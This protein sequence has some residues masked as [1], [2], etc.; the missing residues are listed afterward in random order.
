[1]LTYSRQINDVDVAVF[2]QPYFDSR[3]DQ[4]RRGEL[5]THPLQPIEAAEFFTKLE[6]QTQV[7]LLEWLV[8]IA[9]DLASRFD[10]HSSINIHNSLI[11]PES[12]RESFMKLISHAT[13]ATTFEFTETFRMPPV[14]T[15]NAMLRRVRELGHTTA[16]DDFGTGL[17]GMSL[18]IDYDFDIVKLDQVLI[19]GIEKS[20]KKEKVL[21]LVQEMLSVLGKRHVVEGV[22]TEAVYQHLLSIGYTTFQGFYFSKPV[23]VADYIQKLESGLTT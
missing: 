23:P 20:E 9:N 8:Q 2:F 17:N 18:L 16:L 13:S 6:A 11:E 14:T 22:E 10:V 3:S 1:M 21:A 7:E 12:G 4:P 15:S 5:L 19:K